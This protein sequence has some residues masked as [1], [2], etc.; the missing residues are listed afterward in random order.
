MSLS[1]GDLSSDRHIK[2]TEKHKFL[3][4]TSSHH[5]HTKHS[6]I[7]SQALRISRISSNKFDFLKHF[8]SMKSLFKVRGYLN[9]LIEQEIEKVRFFKNSNVVRHRDP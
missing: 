5:D 7:Y 9:K 3:H 8:E 4:Y 2:S 6:I 1:N